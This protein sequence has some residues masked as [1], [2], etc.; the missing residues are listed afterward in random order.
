MQSLFLPVRLLAIAAL[1]GVLATACGSDEKSGVTLEVAHSTTTDGPTRTPAPDETPNPA[2]L[3]D[4]PGALAFVQGHTLYLYPHGNNPQPVVLSA[5]FDA[6]SLL[7][8]PERDAL[9]Y[10]TTGSTGRG[11]YLVELGTLATVQLTDRFY[12]VTH[13][14]S[15]IWSPD[16]QWVIL[17]IAA[18]GKDLI[19]R[20]G[21][22][23]FHL[24]DNIANQAYWLDDG[25][26]LLIDSEAKGVPPD[27]TVIYRDVS[28]YILSTGETVPLDVDLA[29]LTSDPSGIDDALAALGVEYVS[30]PG[31]SE[32]P[33]IVP[34]EAVDAGAVVVCDDWSIDAA[35]GTG[36]DRVLD[37][38]YSVHDTY[39]LSELRTLED[40]SLSFLEWRIPDCRISNRP[41]VTLKRLVPGAATAGTLA[42]GVFGGVTLGD[43]GTLASTALSP[44]GRY[45]VWIGGGLDVG[46]SSLNLID[47]QTGTRSLLMRETN[48][49]GMNSLFMDGQLYSAVYWVSP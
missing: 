15:A 7:F 31:V 5:D 37:P 49:S 4:L 6:A 3:R 42:E 24:T 26:I 17:S 47:V 27:M 25:S 20:D 33:E 22:Q 8:T 48:T 46:E 45:L 18:R 14:S 9:L 2:V 30:R 39:R 40:G 38:L 32:T 12:Y 16:R 21:A 43:T 41:V 28:R 19:S 10:S 23:R 1:V 11:I 35:T 34:P 29:A 36:A 44:D 13:L